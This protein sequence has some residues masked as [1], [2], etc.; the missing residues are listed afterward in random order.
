[1]IRFASLIILMVCGLGCHQDGLPTPDPGYGYFPLRVG[2]F[3][4]YAVSETTYSLS[5]APEIKNY[6]WRETVE[7]K[8]T[9]ATGQDVF[10]VKRAYTNET[11]TWLADS[12][13]LVWRSV[14][15]ALKSENGQIEVKLI[16]PIAEGIRWNR[17]DF[18]VREEE[19]S[20]ITNIGNTK[21]VGGR[22]YDNTLTVV[23]QNDSTL[24]STQKK[25]EV[26]AEGIGLVQREIRSINYCSTPECAN[27]GSISFGYIQNTTLTKYGE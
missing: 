5:Q 12:L 9:D 7:A 14:D 1:M 10:Q 16:F 11:G 22:I 8:Y 3:V 17:N 18:N 13:F 19:L 20:E 6:Q 25:S 26:Y 2:S 4:E 23:Q 27:Q 24:L 15:R 21:S